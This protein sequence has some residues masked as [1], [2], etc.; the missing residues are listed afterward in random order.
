MPTLYS[1]V[2][3]LLFRILLTLLPL[4]FGA[5][6]LSASPQPLHYLEEFYRMYYLPNIYDKND[7]NRNLYWL[8][9][10]LKVPFAPPIQA[11][12]VP[13]TEEGYEKYKLLLK[14]HINYLMT[15]NS[16][17]LGAEYDKHEPVFF[18]KE[19][20][21]EIL[22]SLEWARYYYQCS[23]N[24]WDVVLDYKKQIEKYRRTRVDM[25][26]TEDLLVRIDS[27]DLDYKRVA[28]RH[29][30]KIEKT[31]QFLNTP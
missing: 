7:L 28:D 31:I 6:G 12:V 14:M 22:E 30:A 27:G 20:K 10:A 2:K 24:Y 18:N 17:F 9:F 26:F 19:Y 16:V 1:S 4:F 13:R 29:L 21:K 15:Q 23:K 3:T 5:N 25:D 8:Q 11:L